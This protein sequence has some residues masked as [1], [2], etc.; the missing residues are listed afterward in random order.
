MPYVL[1][2][3]D[4][5][6][7]AQLLEFNLRQAGLET[8]TA[9]SGEQAL[10][11][12]KRRLPDLIILDLMLPDISGLEVCH[13]LKS[14]SQTRTALILILTAKG[15]ESDRVKGLEEGAD[16]YLT[17][18]F[19]I[20]ELLLR[21]KAILRRSYETEPTQKIHGMMRLDLG[22]H[23]C[24]V[25][26]SEVTLTALEFRLLQHL[27]AA[28]GRVQSREILLEEVWGLSGSLE[29]RTVDTHMM[30]LR[31]KLGSARP[32]LETV[33]GIGYRLLEPD[34]LSASA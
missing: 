25:E 23:R 15:D 32:Y 19:S 33:R 12:A 5:P 6:D 9:H 10:A 7:L 26:E 14:N 34:R 24:F 17:K 3:D 11:E 2:V 21:V 22:S 13:Q 27:M 29:T 31:D 8:V 28:P 20:R 18:P 16:D 4:E 1:I 30:R